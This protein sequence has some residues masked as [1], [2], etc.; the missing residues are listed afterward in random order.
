[1][2][3]R[4]WMVLILLMGL[5]SGNACATRTVYV[6]QAPPPVRVE[7]MTVKPFPNAVWVPGH[8]AW[9]SGQY[10]WVRGHW[11]R[12]RPGYRWVAGHWAKKRRGWVWI[13]GHWKK[14]G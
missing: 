10:V 3:K 11:T 1:M 4:A 6:R 8:W 5:F 14:I 9:R 2:R 7:V 13:P 12:P